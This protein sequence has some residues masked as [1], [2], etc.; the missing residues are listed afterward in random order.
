MLCGKRRRGGG[1]RIIQIVFISIIDVG[2]TREVMHNATTREV[3]Q[4]K[5][6]STDVRFKDSDVPRKVDGSD[7]T[8]GEGEGGRREWERGEGGGGG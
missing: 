3:N 5:H 1:V 4:T 7:V 2:P 8:G 6:N